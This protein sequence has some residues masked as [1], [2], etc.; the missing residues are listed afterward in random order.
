MHVLPPC[1][2]V[3]FNKRGSRI[4]SSSS[5]TFSSNTKGR[6]KYSIILKILTKTSSAPVLSTLQIV[7]VP[8]ATYLHLQWVQRNDVIKTLPAVG[9]I[10]SRSTWPLHLLLLLYLLAKQPGLMVST[11]DSLCL[12]MMAE[13]THFLELFQCSLNF[14]YKNNSYLETQGIIRRNWATTSNQIFF[15]FLSS[16]K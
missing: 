11:W 5:P 10:M 3:C 1:L 9:R 2:K 12:G 6:K 16:V 8:V 13:K 14:Y 4:G 7:S 15:I